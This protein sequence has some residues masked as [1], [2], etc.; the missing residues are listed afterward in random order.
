M[1]YS[2]FVK[3]SSWNYLHLNKLVSKRLCIKTTGNPPRD[4]REIQDGPSLLMGLE[5]F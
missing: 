2:S 3:P 4:L 5:I 1:E